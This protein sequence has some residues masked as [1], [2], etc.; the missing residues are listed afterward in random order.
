VFGGDRGVVKLCAVLVESLDFPVL[1]SE[2]ADNA[3]A[4]KAI[5]DGRRKAAVQMPGSPP[6]IHHAVPKEFREQEDNRRGNKDQE[7]ELPVHPEQY[8]A[9]A[10]EEENV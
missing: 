2:G 10:D 6:N 8:D 4:G 7:R 1:F 3:Y 9:D 5:A